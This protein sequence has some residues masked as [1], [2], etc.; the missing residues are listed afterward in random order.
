MMPFDNDI[1][2]FVEDPMHRNGD[3]LFLLLST[4]RIRCPRRRGQVIVPITAPVHP[5]TENQ[6]VRPYNA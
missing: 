3:F 4:R 5:S 6:S 1:L 2:V